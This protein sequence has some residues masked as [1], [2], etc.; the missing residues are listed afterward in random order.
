MEQ[1][2]TDERNVQILISLLKQ[3]GI[4]KIVASPGS[5]NV[6]IVGSLQQ[7]PYFEMYSCV[8]ERSA[9]Y[10]ACGLAAESGKPVAIS[11]T[12]ATASRNY[13]PALTEAFY[14]KLPILAITSTQD[15]C[16]IGHLIPQV[17]DRSQHP[18]DIV[19]ESVHLQNIKDA[20][21]EWDVTI[22][23]NKAILA[24]NHHGKGPV[25]INLSTRYSNNFLVKELP[26]AHKIDRKTL[27]DE[28]PKIKGN[29]IAIYVGS[30]VRWTNRLTEAVDC[31]CEAYNALVFVE[32]CSNYQG[33]YAVPYIISSCQQSPGQSRNPDL[34]I[35]IGEMSDNCS[36]VGRPKDVWRVSEDGKVVD[37][38]RKLST[39]FEM[40]EEIF[41]E[42]YSEGKTSQKTSYYESAISECRELWNS[43]PKL[44]FSQIWI[45]SQMYDKFPKNSTIHLGI[46]SPLRSWSYFPINKNIEI[47]CNQGGFGI[48]GN[49][50]T[51]IGASMVRPDKIF[52]A[53]VGDLSFFYDMNILGNRHIGRNVR[54]LLVNNSVGVE[55]HLFKQANSIYVDGIDRY[56]SAGGHNGHQSPDLVKHFAT[57]LGF[58]Y[59]Q[60]WTKEEFLQKYERFVTPEM[61]D[62][63]M[64]FE[65][66]TKIDDEN[67][68]LKDLWSINKTLKSDL[69]NLVKETVGAQK[70]GKL[71]KLLG[72]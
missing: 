49:M 53:M 6:T 16:K 58:E 8:D 43:I 61:T 59:L 47:Y 19:K 48:D 18:L 50:S 54:I 46:L 22:K 27:C 64:I 70:V 28:F 34:L 33:K 3:H 60:A 9:A 30:H 14:R 36:M 7:D 37:R 25:H 67:Q 45:A 10:F 56:I 51:M 41:F 44:P 57:D 4:K 55:F 20:D 71:I 17:L 13:F 62:K 35:H 40:P 32:P 15:E 5:T 52:Y 11:C 24:L 63:P 31:F 26:V 23:A 39:V 29:K 38:Y 42:K 69:K 1:Y 2:Y 21:D 72:R 65:V 12:G 66:F 68:A